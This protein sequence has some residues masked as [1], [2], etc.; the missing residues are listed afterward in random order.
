MQLELGSNVANCEDR[1]L[2][3]MQEEVPIP[4]TPL[5]AVGLLVLCICVPFGKVLLSSVQ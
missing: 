3:V 2:N 5:F 1:R 4:T